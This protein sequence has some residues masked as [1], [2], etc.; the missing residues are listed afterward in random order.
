MAVSAA[1]FDALPLTPYSRARPNL[2]TG[3]IV[4]FHS[5]AVPSELIEHF[6]DSLWCHAAIV[7]NVMPPTDRVMLLESVDTFGVR[8]LRMSSKINGCPA[9]PSAYPGKIL[10]AR[11]KALAGGMSEEQAHLM[12]EFAVDRLGYPYSPTELVRI[13]LRIAAGLAGEALPGFLTPKNA[14]ICSE[15]VAECFQAVGIDLVP[16]KEGFIA[17]ADI[18]N[19]PNV[20]PLFSLVHDASA[21]VADAA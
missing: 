1:Q 19:D 3:D 13:G 6:T 5:S 14:Y 7:W 4:L 20:E 10:I 21:D 18:A 8:A 9:S 16:D 12:T 11:H 2:R 17:P 15:Y